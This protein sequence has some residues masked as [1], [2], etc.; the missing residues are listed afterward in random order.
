MSRSVLI[1]TLPLLSLGLLAAGGSAA[2]TAD[3][4][5]QP[6][7]VVPEQVKEL[8]TL[9]QGST[10]DLEFRL[11]NEG[12][13]PLEIRATRPGPG[14][15]VEKL[16]ETIAP[17]E[18]AVIRATLDTQLYFGESTSGIALVTNDPENERISLTIEA[19]VEPKVLAIPGSARWTYVRYER[20]GTIGHTVGS[21]DGEDFEILRVETPVP[22]IQAS[23]RKAESDEKEEKLSGSQWRV[24]LTLVE[25]APVGP[26]EGMVEVYTDHP[27]QEMVVIPISGF[28]RPVAHITP[29]EGD[30]GRLELNDPGRAVF[31]VTNFSTEPMKITRIEHGVE[32]LQ[33][34]VEVREEG[35]RFHVILILDPAQMVEGDFQ[36]TVVI[37]TD[38]PRRP[39]LRL[40]IHGSL[41]FGSG[42]DGPPDGR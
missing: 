30:F 32:G 22:H 12:T 9:V 6:R 3:A 38:H 40:P 37:H 28:V 35:H 5:L 14:I 17:G 41:V 8:G 13:A 4:E 18:E 42:G 25:D 34:K 21:T 1:L 23:F 31:A 16:D 20:T 15:T 19:T 33:T 29:S 36:D 26:L 10:V 2:T 39:T 24:L 11:R 27:A 7:A